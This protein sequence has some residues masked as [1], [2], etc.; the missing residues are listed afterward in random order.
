MRPNR[1]GRLTRWGAVAMLLL[2]IHG[3]IAPRSASA[4]CNH[5]VSSHTDRL[6]SLNQDQ[7]HRLWR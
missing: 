6:L 3:L 1:R 5:L 2:L 4:G 7:I